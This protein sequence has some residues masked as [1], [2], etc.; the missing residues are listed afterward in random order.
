[1]LKG[2]MPTGKRDAIRRGENGQL[3]Q[4]FGLRGTPGIY[5]ANASKSA[6]VALTERS[7][8]W[9]QG[10]TPGA[11][12]VTGHDGRRCVGS[13][14]SQVTHG[15]LCERAHSAVL[16]SALLHLSRSN[17]TGGRRARP[18]RMRPR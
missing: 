18:P 14:A 17:F 12:G 13:L 10:S 2:V 16:A 8:P 1:M 4:R 11:S 15:T 5:R 3:A 6:V 9:Q 7:R